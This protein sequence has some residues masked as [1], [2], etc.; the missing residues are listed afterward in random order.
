M[1]LMQL[2]NGYVTKVDDDDFKWLNQW[3]WYAK[4]SAYTIYACRSNYN[5]GDPK[6]IRMHRLI[7]HCPDDKEIDHKDG[8]GLNNQKSNLEIVTKHENIFREQRPLFRPHPPL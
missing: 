6:T 5:K 7:M 1:M 4:P 8:D 3:T 2:N